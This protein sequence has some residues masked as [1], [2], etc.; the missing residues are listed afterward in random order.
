MLPPRAMIKK[1]FDGH[2]L[3]IILAFIFGVARGATPIVMAYFR[4]GQT[5]DGQGIAI[6]FLVLAGTAVAAFFKNKPGTWQ[7]AEEEGENVGLPPGPPAGG[8][9]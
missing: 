6:G 9:A 4:P 5:V 3:I 7:E 2:H 1:P 8:A